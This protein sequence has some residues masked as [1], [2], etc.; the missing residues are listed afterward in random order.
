M[1]LVT[2]LPDSGLLGSCHTVVP[3]PVDRHTLSRRRWR[4][5]AAD[6]TDFAVALEAPCQH[7]QLLW[8]DG[9]KAYCVDQ[10]PENVIEVPLPAE[11][12]Q[13]ASLGWFLGNQHLPVE[14]TSSAVRLEFQRQLADLLTRRQ[15]AFVQTTARFC[16][17]AHSAAHGHHAHHGHLHTSGEEPDPTAPAAAR[18]L[19]SAGP[20]HVHAP[21]HDPHAH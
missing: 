10:S 18:F 3:V 19:P 20:S 15:I 12:D 17:T 9:D 14:V 2:I 4:V 11:P 7:G 8:V 16:P 13:A 5:P 21:G 6:G 1:P